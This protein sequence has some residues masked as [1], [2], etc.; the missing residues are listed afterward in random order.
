VPTDLLDAITT[1]A[2]RVRLDE[3]VAERGDVRTVLYMLGEGRKLEWLHSLGVVS[4]GVLRALAPPIPPLTLRSIVAD[5]D[6]AVF[7]WTGVRDLCFFLDLYE[8]FAS[9]I[10]PRPRVLDFACGCGRLT[11]YLG[12]MARY[13]AFGCDTN[14]DHVAWCREN[15]SNVTTLLNE[16]APP[17]P[18]SPAAFDFA[19]LLSL[20]THL[21]EGAATAWL[22]DLARVMAPGGIVA[23]TTHGDTALQTIRASEAHQRMCGFDDRTARDLLETL[24]AR[25]YIFVPYEREAAARANVGADYGVSFISHQ[26]AMA[27]WSR[28]F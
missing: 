3:L 6:E 1:P 27:M 13:E 23:V 11:R 20:L 28:H 8:R 2:M 5:P 14:G 21:P 26:H 7:L 16:T 10:P 17:L 24:D 9:P 4:D 18:F 22:A 19:Y 12:G 15:L 25:R